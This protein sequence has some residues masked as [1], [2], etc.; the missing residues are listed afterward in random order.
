M[1]G[2]LS[3]RIQAAIKAGN[4]Y[5]HDWAAESPISVSVV[6]KAVVPAVGKIAAKAAAA[7]MAAKETTTKAERARRFN[8]EEDVAASLRQEEMA[9]KMRK[10]A[11]L[12]MAED[13]IDWD[14]FSIIGTSQNL[15]KPYLRL[16]SVRQP[17]PFFPLP[18][19]V[20][21]SPSYRHPIRPPC[22]LCPC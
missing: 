16:T 11:I 5:S 18:P 7:K 6:P 10:S 3:A 22:G 13:G 1:E 17:A 2:A 15:E 4:L 12:A 8:S 19:T 21:S 14:E 9:K 20:H